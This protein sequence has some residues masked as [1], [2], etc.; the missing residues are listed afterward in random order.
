MHKN[1]EAKHYRFLVTCRD[2]G[3]PVAVVEATGGIQA[4]SRY[5]RVVHT[6]N[7]GSSALSRGFGVSE[8][9]DD[10]LAPDVPHFDMHHFALLNEAERLKKTSLPN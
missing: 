5:R 9:S 2:M 3:C 1:E 7:T 4:V 8:M 6:I 10:E